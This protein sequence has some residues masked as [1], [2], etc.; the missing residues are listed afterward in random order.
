MDTTGTLEVLE[1]HGH[2]VAVGWAEEVM[3]GR[4]IPAY[5]IT[6]DTGYRAVFEACPCD[7]TPCPIPTIQEP[8]AQHPVKGKRGYSAWREHGR[9]HCHQWHEGSVRTMAQWVLETYAPD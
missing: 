5:V 7:R 8:Q 2:W 3:R 6:T 1:G 4:M 9:T